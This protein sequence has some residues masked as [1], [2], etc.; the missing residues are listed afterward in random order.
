VVFGEK[1]HSAQET[2]VEAQDVAA[3][4]EINEQR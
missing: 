1:G 3:A 4:A 2:A